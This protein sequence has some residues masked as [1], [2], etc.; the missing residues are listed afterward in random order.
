MATWNRS[1][2]RG[3]VA[4]SL[5]AAAANDLEELKRVRLEHAGSTSVPGLPA[6]PILDLIL[7]VDDP[8]DEPAYVPPLEGAGFALRIRE[9]DWFEHRMLRRTDPVVNLHVFASDSPE[10]D[11]ILAFRDRLR[12]HPDERARY[13]ET[14]RD[15]A[16]RDWVYLQDYAD[17]KSEVVEAIVARALADDASA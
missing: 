1:D 2:R 11:R 13:A 16:A 10:I 4:R 12:S 9:P 7:G 6:K 17:A 3:F 15:L 14:K 8:A 5:A